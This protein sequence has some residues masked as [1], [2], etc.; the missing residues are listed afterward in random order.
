MKRT[1]ITSVNLNNRAHSVTA[2]Q[3]TRRL[4]ELADVSD[5][6]VTQEAVRGIVAPDGFRPLPQVGAGAHEDRILVREDLALGLT[7]HGY[8]RAHRGRSHKWPAR[9]FPWVTLGAGETAQAPDLTII[10]LHLNSG[11]DAGG[12]WAVPATDE[13]REFAEAYIDAVIDLGRL[14]RNRLSD[15]VVIL[16]DTNVDAY[17]DQRHRE[18]RMPAARFGRYHFPEA[19]PGK[20]SGTLGDRRVDRVFHSLDL[21]V[22]VTDRAKVDAWGAGVHQA[23]TATAVRK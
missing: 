23:I 17:A 2:Q 18:A 19:L 13:R 6:I 12:M 7:G 8:M 10:G 4:A 1:R 5:V 16:G 21:T 14:V 22:T 15:S 11:I 20:R 3:Q 9:W